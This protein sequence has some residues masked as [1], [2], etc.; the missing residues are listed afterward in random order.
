MRR[1]LSLL[2]Y[3]SSN[4]MVFVQGLTWTLLVVAWTMVSTSLVVFGEDSR[5]KKLTYLS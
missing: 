4:T 2:A 3:T 5:L 1:D